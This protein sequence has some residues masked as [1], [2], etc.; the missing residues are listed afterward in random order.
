LNRRKKIALSWP[1][2]H[3]RV[4]LA[5][6]LSMPV[7]L[8][9]LFIFLYFPRQLK[10]Q[11]VRMVS[12]KAEAIADLMAYSIGPS[13]FYNDTRALNEMLGGTVRNGAL[14]YVFVCDTTG[15]L[16]SG[17]GLLPEG[18]GPVRSGEDPVG[19]AY[20]TGRML[21]L[22]GKAVGRLY[23][24]ISVREL[25]AQVANSRR[26]TALVSLLVCL[27]GLLASIGLSRLITRP[28]IQ[29]AGTADAIAAGDLSQ[30]ARIRSRDE[31]GR[32][33]ESFNAMVNRLQNAY[34][35]LETLNRD[36][37]W[38]V[39]ERTD[40]MKSEIAERE[41]TEAALKE[42]YSRLQALMTAIPDIIHFKDQDNRIRIVNRA[43][44]RLVGR[45]SAEILGKTDAEV[46]PGGI[47][48]LNRKS[49]AETLRKRRV[50]RHTE[51]VTGR[52]GKSIVLE[53]IKAPLY[54]DDGK[55]LGLVAVGRDITE[56][57]RLDEE[58]KRI[59]TQLMQAQKMEAV[60]ILAGGI[61]HDF[62]NLLTAIIGTA[63]MALRQMNSSHPLHAGLT[64]I[65][66]AG[67]RAA[68]LTRQLLYFSRKQH[69]QYTS[70]RLN[71]LIEN[72]FS[73]FHRI[74]GEDIEIR[75]E[76]EPGCRPIRGDRGTMEQVIM[77]LVVNARD[78]MPRGGRLVL[79]TENLDMDEAEGRIVPD[80][81]VGRFVRL[82]VSDTGTGM[83]KETQQHIFEPF[84][85]TKEVG[86]GTGLGLSVVY[87][88]IKQHGGWVNV[89]SE[90]GVGSTF[91]IYLPAA[92]GNDRTEEPVKGPSL[93]SVRGRGERV[94]L[95]EDEKRLNQFIRRALTEN[96]YDVMAAENAD[97]AIR[98]FER[99]NGRFDLVLSDVVLPGKD[100]LEL[101]N[102]LLSRKPDLKVLLSSGYTDH[103]NQ[104]PIIRKKGYRFLPKPYSLIE[105]LISIRDALSELTALEGKPEE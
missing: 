60:G 32:L 81:K 18:I 73:M 11:A 89:Y 16:V 71:E 61:A 70:L 12:A 76:L 101:L 34:A 30:R 21:A 66:T 37:E 62:N 42:T 99:E 20:R 56:Q 31:I 10:R 78:A 25:E 50:T 5:I 53:T 103:K 54:D 43:F 94:L 69:M 91:K 6:F 64:D 8:V 36:L 65:H 90:M 14:L 26:A 63:E 38:R 85:T 75:T 83:D 84:F 44:E 59:E 4:K 9:S 93:D 97:Q 87:G 98:L 74:I 2:R 45:E 41:K 7:V 102:D 27:S 40:K 39:S 35:A 1:I 49:D 3:F 17:A 92:A 48:D 33:A 96:G 58:K 80:G 105:L 86:K 104:W 72:L 79:K 95:I 51:R 67:E 82:T 68:D 46:L 100:G 28:L 22:R 13:V 24:G 77:N 47:V 29:I 57:V 52:N 19:G 55:T 23:L 15:R 88:V